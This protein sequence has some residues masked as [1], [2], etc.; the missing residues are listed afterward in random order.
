M[1]TVKSIFSEVA[2]DDGFRVL[3]EPFRSGNACIKTK[4]MDMWLPYLAPSAELF[5]R[6][7]KNLIP[8]EEFVSRYHGELEDKRESLKDLQAHRHYSGLTLLHGSCNEDRNSAVALKMFLENDHPGTGSSV[9]S[10]PVFAPVMHPD[11]LARD[12]ASS[13]FPKTVYGVFEKP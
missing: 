10:E 11:W 1:I 8:W 9:W 5:I 6:Y 2:D 7:S 4:V 13:G 12:P 3:V